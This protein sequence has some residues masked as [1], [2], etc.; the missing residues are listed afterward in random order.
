V[1]KVQI[2]AVPLDVASNDIKQLEQDA[3][4]AQHE[5][6]N[7][8]SRD[9]FMANARM[10]QSI[11][12]Y[13]Q[14]AIRIKLPLTISWIKDYLEQTDDKLVVACVHREKCGQILYDNFKD[15]SVLI[16]GS[17]S[18]KKKDD[19]VQKFI[20][21]PDCRLLIGNIQSISTGLDGLQ[22]VCSTLLV[23]E[24]CWSPGDLHQL[25]ARLD[26]NGQTEPVVCYIHFV[27][28][29]LDERLARMLD[30]KTNILSEVLDGVSMNDSD[31]LSHMITQSGVC[32]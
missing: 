26:R 22:T 25:Y 31:K 6:M 2:R 27:E 10:N 29:S 30:R 20:N 3:I 17:V 14:E 7:A 21:D 24:L 19:A 11:E 15:C 4:R 9:R 5:Y 28:N 13:L 1:P 32:C 23:C 16:N 8:C 18:T 12:A